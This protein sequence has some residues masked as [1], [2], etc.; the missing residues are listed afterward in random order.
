[1]RLLRITYV[2]AVVLFVAATEASAQT[3]GPESVARGV[4]VATRP[5]PEFDPLGVRLGGFRLDGSVEGGAGFSDNLVPDVG[6]NR[7]GAFFDET[8]RLG[9]NSDWTRHAIGVTASQATRQHVRDSDLN[10]LD[11]AVGLN[12]RYDIGRASSLGLEYDHIR[13]HLEVTDFDAE[14]VGLTRP[15]PFDTDRVRVNGTAAIN[16]IS[17]TS[18]LE[19]YRIRYEEEERE[20]LGGSG[21]GRVSGRDYER[22]LGEAGVAY[23]FFP[24]R[25]VTFTTRLS[26]INYRREDRSG[27]NSFTWEVLGG[28]RYDLTGLWAVRFA[29]G[30][31]HRDY[32]GAELRS[33]SG[34]AFEGQVVYLPSQLTTLTLTASRTIEESIRA[35]SVSFVRTQVRLGADY[36]LRRNIILSGEV[37][38]ER[39][40]YQQPDEKVTDLVGVVGARFLLNRNL[41]LIA[42][43][44]HFERLQ[45][46]GGAREF[47]QNLFQLRLRFAL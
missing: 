10:W 6:R 45:A 36:E 14:Q 25:A 43:Y 4:T 42:S 30:Y 27:V 32:E 2:A 28:V 17:L 12:G 37:R 24:G 41:S 38:G 16:R 13:G 29:A 1:M 3:M 15:V 46:P 11:Y 22:F 26:D 18:A 33:L 21:F 23:N 5:R 9:L 35:E 47:G 44:Q 20:G 39:R 7:S 19:Y 34:P 31:R 8:V 40:E